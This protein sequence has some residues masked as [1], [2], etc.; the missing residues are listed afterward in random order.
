M[1][2]IFL[3]AAVAAVGVI[4]TVIVIRYDGPTEPGIKPEVLSVGG[5]QVTIAWLST[6]LYKG[7]VLYKPAGSDASP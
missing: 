2:K 6:D 5:S 3:L 7:R 4:G 1:R